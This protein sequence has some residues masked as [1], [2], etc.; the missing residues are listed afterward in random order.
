[1]NEIFAIDPNAPQDLKDISAMLKQFGLEHGRFIAK[2]PNDWVNMLQVH[3]HQLQGL[4]RARLTRLL[5]LHKDALLEVPDDFRRAKSWIENATAAKLRRQ[6]ISRILAADMNDQGVETL[7]HFLWEDDSTDSSRGGHISMSTDAYRRTVAPLFQQS[8]EIH[9]VDSFF[10]L[11]RANGELHRGRASV[12]R[13]FLE[14]A[15]ESGRTELF[16]IHFKREAHL[17]K[18]NQEDQIDLDLNDLCEQAKIKKINVHY[19]VWDEMSHGRYVFSI[20]GGLQFDHGFEPLREK[21]NHVHWLSKA[22]LEP[23]IRKYIS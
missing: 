19:C 14:Q 2:F 3:V 17:T 13:E 1:M 20:K 7:N 5:E 8:T 9:L 15:D 6:S 18:V 10:Q 16:T 21:T 12:L 4:D 11:R 22:E 23:I